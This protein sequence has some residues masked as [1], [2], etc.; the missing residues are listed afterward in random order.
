MF[1]MNKCLE[2]ADLIASNS[3]NVLFELE[4]ED[5][6]STPGGILAR[7]LKSA[8]CETDVNC[9][10]YNGSEAG[11]TGSL[12]E[13]RGNVYP[14]RNTRVYVCR[15]RGRVFRVAM[16]SDL[17]EKALK[18][19]EKLKRAYKIMSERTPSGV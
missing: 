15:A 18:N 1:L 14:P 5:L 9:L 10:Y 4:A 3:G 16:D 6:K 2:N 17:F 19:D 11:L 8:E 7:I 12:H 13:G